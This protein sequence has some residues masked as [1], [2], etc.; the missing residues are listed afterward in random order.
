MTK[1]S[2]LD[3]S[4]PLPLIRGSESLSQTVVW[5]IAWLSLICGVAFFWGLAS[6]G[7]VDETEP[8]FA[9]A[10]RQMVETGNWITPYFNEVTRFDKPP[11]VYWLMAIG[12]QIWGT[13][14]WA[15]RLPSALSATA[16]V[17][18][19]FYTLRR[20]G[21]SRSELATAVTGEMNGSAP[22]R[23]RLSQQNLMW[24][25]LIGSAIMALHPETIVWA[26]IGVSDMLLSSCIGIALLSFF[27]AYAQP[28]FPQRQRNWYL[29]AY[30]F[31]GLAVLA[32]G[33]VGLVLPGLTVLAFAYYTGQFFK[34][35]RELHLV[36][37]AIIF[38][39]ITVPWNVLVIAENGRAYIDA[40]FGYHNVERFTDVV[41]GH[42]AP[43]YFYFLVVAV[44]FLPWSPLL[45]WAIARLRPQQRQFW[46]SQ[47]RAAHLGL[48]ALVWFVVIFGFFTIAVTKLPSYVLPLMPALAILVGLGWSDRLCSAPHGSKDSWGFTLSCS[49]NLVVFGLLTFAALYSPNWMGNDPA[50]PGLPELMR[51]SGI[52]VRAAGI[53]TLALLVGTALIVSR[54]SRWLWSVNLVA[55]ATFIMLSILPA[56]QLADQV[57]QAPLRE[58]AT[59]A[60][61]QQQSDESLYMVGFMKP[62]LVFY[63]QQPVTYIERSSELRQTLQAQAPNSSA[64]VVGTADEIADINWPIAQQTAL[65]TTD[66]YHLVRLSSDP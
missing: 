45:P 21:F 22:Q 25:A 52:M 39:A 31:L 26:R 49:L 66:T 57:R 14:E 16:L 44:G 37:G 62:S 8:L 48:F 23:S 65:V 36:K 9:E 46:Q 12:M 40:F 61:A 53:W 18:L 7:L 35:L 63:T 41:N 11:L 3:S 34:L 20:F 47:P 58:I 43:W 24:S 28:E 6:I 1:R 10:A 55:F 30:V 29:I 64:L 19:G 2:T 56:L 51:E 38:G 4:P 13:G 60:I 54:R 5:S 17:G 59:A 42:A 27:L 15:V 50:M 33:P 32:K